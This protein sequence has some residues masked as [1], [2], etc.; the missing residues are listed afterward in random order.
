M[1][2][3]LLAALRILPFFSASAAVDAMCAS[4]VVS[5]LKFQAGTTLGVLGRAR[6]T[7]RCFEAPWEPAEVDAGG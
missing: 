6:E 5:S 3:A 2:D 1:S 4:I 7:R